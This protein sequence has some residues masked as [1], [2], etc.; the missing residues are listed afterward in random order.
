MKMDN[1]NTEKIISYYDERV[2]KAG[3]SGH[4]TLLDDNMRMVEVD[5]VRSWLK[6][7]DRALEIF[8]GNGVSTL[9]FAEACASITACDLSEK[10]IDSAKKNLAQQNPPR[11]NVEFQNCNVM[12]IGTIFAPGQFNTV[13][14]VRGLSN[15]P[16]REMQ[17]QAMIQVHKLL[18]PKGKFLFLEGDRDGLGRINEHRSR[19]G[20]KPLNEPWYDNYFVEPEL[21]DFLS[22]YFRVVEEKKMDIY[23]LVSRILYPFAALPDEAS[24]D[25]LCNTVARLLVPY[26]DTPHGTSMMKCLYLEKI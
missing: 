15:L 24:F 23:F 10:M 14:T 2:T 26:A 11:T 25:H 1:V 21:S 5:I 4:A 12:D 16:T 22:G 13:I 17:K 8:C 9:Q 7:D 20:L 3:E 18:P 19:L 6:P